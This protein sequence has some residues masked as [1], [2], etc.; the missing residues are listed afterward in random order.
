MT[1]APALTLVTARRLTPLLHHV[2]ATLA[3]DPLSP[4][5]REII[6]VQSQGMRRWLTL[7][8][9][10]LQG[11]AGSIDM[12][13]P[14]AFMHDLAARLGADAASRATQ[15]AF[16]RDVMTWRIDALLRTLPDDAVFAPLHAYLRGSDD[17][18]RFG[19]AERIAG[20][21]D[22]YQLYR[23]DLLAAWEDGDDTPGTAHAAWQ[24]ALWRTL[25][26]GAGV[27]A[28]HAGA[29]LHA[30]LRLLKSG[31]PR[32]IRRVTVFGVSTL[33]PIFLELLAT[34]AEHVP[35]TIC[36]ASLTPDTAHPV[37]DALGMQGREFVTMLRE[38]GATHVAL[39]DAAPDTRGL[40]GQLQSELAGGSDGSAPLALRRDDATLRIHSAHGA[41]R[42]LE[43]VRDQLLDAMAADPTLRPHDLLLL[44]P[45][46]GT[47]APLVDAVFGASETD[48][49]RI[50]YRIADRPARG[51]DPAAE[52]LG[53]LLALQG[54]RFG[55]TEVFELLSRTLVHDSAGLT[56]AQ[57]DALRTLTARANV[58]WGYDAASRTALGLPAYEEATWRTSLDRLVLG[59]V[60]GQVDDL[61]LGVLPFAGDTAGDV[62]A[63]ARLASWI[64][65]LALMLDGWNTPRPVAAWVDAMR[66]AVAFTMGAAAEDDPQAIASVLSLLLRLDQVTDGASYDDA[67]PFGVVRDWLEQ[68]LAGDG[69]GS[70]FLTG[71]MTVAALKPMRSL[72]FRV[73]AVLGLDEGIFPRR[74]RRTAFDMLEHEH[75]AGD[76]DLR[77][78]DR[79]LFLDLLLAAQDRLILAYTGRAVSDNTPCASSVV[80]DEL[81]DHLDRRSGG[82]ARQ[83]VRVEHPLQ[84]FSH[85]YFEPGRDPRLFTFST[86]HARSAHASRKERRTEPKFVTSPIVVPPPAATATFELSIRDLAE[87]W[88]DPARYF[89]RHALGFTISADD[90]DEA[91]DDELLMPDAM[92]Q[93]T[94][95]AGMLHVALHGDADADH[96]IRLLQAGGALPPGELGTAW[97]SALHEPVAAVL[98]ML[99]VG[100]PVQVVPVTVA[101]ADWRVSGTLDGVRGDVRYLLRAGAFRAKH[102]IRAWIEHVVMCAAAEQGVGG[103][104]PQE[105]VL[106][107]VEKQ[108]G[109]EFAR[110]PAVPDATALL[111]EL[112]EC[113]RQGREFPLPFFPQA[114]AAWLAAH[115]GNA[116]AK[117]RTERD[118]RADAQAAYSRDDEYSMAGDA[119]DVHVDLCFRGEDPL[120]EHWDEFEQLATTLFAP[121]LPGGAA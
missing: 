47:W 77:S 81:L 7:Q 24:A 61:V 116:N 26:M 19:L 102:E 5:E 28:Q 14:A 20:R 114:A 87:C 99:P 69:F 80:L 58:R 4:L 84:P 88:C 54:A 21:F 55:H 92:E 40:L 91:G 104:I 18:A 86:A 115:L 46:T 109:R 66:E 33:P 31:G 44:V 3:S 65:R 39:P 60:T 105:T 12:P 51:E 90:G 85:R 1:L 9:A 8:L 27:G 112:V 53:M 2:A 78:D 100:Y 13:F 16:A 15:N 6:V 72:P 89:C 83:V 35:V 117:R 113:A 41:V 118:P 75:R 42:Q 120:D 95:R 25:C 62:G 110:F 23:A 79:Q 30:A 50:P 68:E 74:E 48:A 108:T 82:A 10:D 29:R 37:A 101:H 22:D 111:A 71:G 106:L 119:A 36:S 67:V 76:R 93:G 32:G 70:G 59:M 73:I 34:L 52:A 45:D 49:A 103:A 56:G 64:D 97:G 17:R 98:S 43:I 94:I 121:R 57:V 38:R 63:V 96:N 107:G 11:C